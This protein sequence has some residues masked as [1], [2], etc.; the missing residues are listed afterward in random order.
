MPDDI[1]QVRVGK[2]LIGLR[3]IPEIFQDLAAR[4]W[5]TPEAAQEE[6]LHRVA[7]QNYI[8]S[9]SRED[10]RLAVWREFRRFRGE[11]AEVETPAQ[12]E[13]K[14]LGLGCAGCQKFYQQVMEILAVH[15]IV[16]DLQYITD[17]ALLKS[18]EV[19]AFPALVINGRMVLA[20]QIPDPAALARLVLTHADPARG[21]QS[22]E[23][24]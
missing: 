5:A 13:I 14:V 17:P 23:R 7:G 21:E 19:R 3:G 6:L 20:G 18:C 8:P 2:N 4:D 15:A 10:Y 24:N 16:A 1:T 22:G 12:L 11:P 9:G